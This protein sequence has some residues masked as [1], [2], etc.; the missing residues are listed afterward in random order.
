MN[1][2]QK[3]SEP[4]KIALLA[5]GGD[6]GGV[7]TGWM[8]QLAEK[9]GYWAQY[10]YIAGVA[11]RTGA[12]VYY[13]EM[14]PMQA[15]KKQGEA[16]VTPVLAQMPAPQDV[17]ILMAT[18]LMEAG[19]AVQR[20]FVSKK[21]TM[22]FSTNRSLAIGEKEVAGDGILDG[23]QV[24]EMTEKY[25]K[26]S[27]FGN[28]KLIA[29]K[30]G[31]VISSSLFGALAAS[32]ALPFKKA[33]YEEVIR[34]GGKGIEQ[35]L[36]AFD[37]AYQYIKAFID[38]PLPYQPDLKPAS[39][40]AMPE[41]SPSKA[42]TTLI[43]EID[44]Q[45]PKQ[46]HAIAWQGV[47]HLIDFQ[48]MAYAKDYLS[49]LKQLVALDNET[50]D[51]Q[52]SQQVAH[53]LATAMAYDDLIFVADEKTRKSRQ[54]S[55]Y[56]QVGAKEDE[57]VNTLDYL[58]PGYEELVGFLPVK[59]GKHLIKHP[60]W[61][62]RYERW[63]NKKRRMHSNSFFGFLLLYFIGGLRGW[64]LRTLRHHDE[65]QMIQGWLERIQQALTVNYDLAVVLAKT[66]RLKKGYSDTYHR[67]QSKFVLVNRY[68]IEHLNR[69]QIEEQVS[70][71]LAV[72]LQHHEIEKLQQQINDL[73][74]EDENDKQNP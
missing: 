31:S 26:K 51:Y 2:L 16:V 11:Q 70:H 43:A 7:L 68:A 37:E 24:F 41:Q 47:N 19:R 14:Y 56:Q 39:F 66:Y 60:K 61:R 28:L 59:W 42:L 57:V 13:I 36:K 71:L 1:D 5:V 53:Y 38:Q 74:E 25:A 54:A 32:G 63:F 8:T 73:T 69:P 18:E 10:T 12:T 40:Q 6:G 67:G 72:A 44:K 35:S 46:M 48:N 65:M 22:I 3:Q 33:A 55:V 23:E 20:G 64:R 17:D 50:K 52:L 9:N 27:L 62:S 58:R 45:L 15:L 21:T 30:N 49:R 29:S 34:A 4:I